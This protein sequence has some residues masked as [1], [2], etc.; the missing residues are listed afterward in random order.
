M[1]T[2]IYAHA[3]RYGGEMMIKVMPTKEY[4]DGC[5]KDKN[6]TKYIFGTMH[7]NLVEVELCLGCRKKMAELLKED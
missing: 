3:L 1:G 6:V 2:V 4:C 5:G 7:Y